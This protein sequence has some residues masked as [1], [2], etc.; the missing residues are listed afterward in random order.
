MIRYVFSETAKTTRFLDKNHELGIKAS[1]P[2]SGTSSQ[3]WSR[4]AFRSSRR[5]NKLM[6]ANVADPVA[7]DIGGQT[8]N[9]WVNYAVPYALGA[10]PVIVENN[11][12]VE[13]QYGAIEIEKRH[14]ACMKK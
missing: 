6:M 4:C 13:E 1:T 8:P 11:S 14:R 7:C 5:S 12:R 2:R 10:V 3:Q 9:T